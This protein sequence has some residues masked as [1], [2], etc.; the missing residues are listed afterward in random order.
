MKYGK[1]LLLLSIL[2]LPLKAVA[3]EVSDNIVSVLVEE[4]ELEQKLQGNKVF[5]E[6]LGGSESSYNPNIVNDI[7]AIGYW[8]FMP[9]TLKDLGYGHITTRKFKANPHIFPKEVQEK[10]L[11]KKI[12]L[13]IELLTDQWFRDSI[14]DVNYFEKYVGTT[15]RGI[16]VTTTGILAMCHLGGAGG[17]MNFL[18]SQGKKNP[19]DLYNTSLLN[20]LDKFSEYNYSF[21]E[22]IKNRL[23]C[24]R[25]SKIYIENTT[26]SSELLK[27]TR[28]AEV[29]STDM[30]T[31]STSLMGSPTTSTLK[32][33]TKYSTL[34]QE[35]QCSYRN[36][37]EEFYYSEVLLRRGMDYSLQVELGKWNGTMHKPGSVILIPRVSVSFQKVIGLISSTSNRFGM[38]RGISN[39]Q[40]FFQYTYWKRLR[41][42][43]HLGVG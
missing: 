30:A 4:Y 18:D 8:Q 12:A 28:S 5:K 27:L 29:V 26:R 41:N 2:L 11:D 24:L 25:N 10:A 23:K 16:K 35:F 15:I 34:I 3:N 40:T 39:Y 20:Y 14:D 7:G 36:T 38:L 37:T 17:A 9:Y 32:I 21:E 33:K 31:V 1:L 42:L 6:A 43:P 22:P 13:D 19:R